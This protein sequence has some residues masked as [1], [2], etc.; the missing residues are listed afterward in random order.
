MAMCWVRGQMGSLSSVVAVAEGEALATK[1]KLKPT[2]R[3]W[4][5]AHA[6]ATERKQ[7]TYRT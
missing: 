7:K 3:R 5:T 4:I 6:I 2:D 1:D